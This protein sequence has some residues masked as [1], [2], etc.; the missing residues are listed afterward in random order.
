M[1]KQSPHELNNILSKIV[2]VVNYRGVL[3]FKLIG[4]FEC[5]GVKCKTPK[6][7]DALIDASLKNLENSLK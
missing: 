3:V 5:L 4:G 6:D 7:V 1:Q 2:P